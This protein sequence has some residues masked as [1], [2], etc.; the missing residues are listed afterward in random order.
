MYISIYYHTVQLYLLETN[1]DVSAQWKISLKIGKFLIAILILSWFGLWLS[2][3]L[4]QF[5]A[6]IFVL[7]QKDCAYPGIKLKTHY[8]KAMT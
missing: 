7:E 3:F 2:N 1:F 6:L 5:N 4:C 8:F